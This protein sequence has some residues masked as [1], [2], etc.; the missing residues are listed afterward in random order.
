MKN[1]PYLDKPLV[2]LAVAL[3]SML[4]ETDTKIATAEPVE[5][6]RL[7]QRA[8]VLR[9]WAQINSA[10]LILATYRAC[11]PTPSRLPAGLEAGQCC[12]PAL[13]VAELALETPGYP[14]SGVSIESAK[15]R[16]RRNPASASGSDALSIS[17]AILSCRAIASS[18]R[19]FNH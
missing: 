10:A 17:L 16:S 13:D 3:R 4:A 6:E 18:R 1:S 8:Q 15:V 5:K 14:R 7:Q 19:A 2:P 11:W 9:E 12:P